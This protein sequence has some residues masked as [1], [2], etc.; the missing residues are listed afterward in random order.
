MIKRHLITTGCLAG[1][2]ALYLAGI[3]SGAA[4]LMV[5]GMLFE[6]AFWKRILSAS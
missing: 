6:L 2:L 1:A 4:A 3:E 5:V